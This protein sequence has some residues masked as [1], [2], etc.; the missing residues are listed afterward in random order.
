MQNRY[1]KHKAR[2]VFIFVAIAVASLAVRLLMNYRF[3]ETALLYVGIPFAIALAL[4]LLR[5]PSEDVGWKKKYLNK[6]I[7]AFIIM[8]GTSVVLFEG[9]VCVVMFMPIYL[10]VILLMF[11]IDFATQHANKHS[12]S[13][14]S[15]HIL[16][17]LIVLSSLEGVVAPLSFER[18]EHVV[19]TRVVRASVAEIQHNLLQSMDLQ[20]SRPWFLRLFPMPYAIKAGSLSPGDVHEIHFRYYRWFVTNMHEG[21]MLLQISE[22]SEKRIKTRILED[23]SYIAN[24]L[25]LKGTEVVLQ[26]IDDSRT[27]VTL[28]VDFERTLDP[29]W[30]FAPVERYGI[31]KTAEF[32]IT[33]VIA[34]E[35]S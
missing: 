29:Y 4:I 5:S 11:I 10:V 35:T 31:G 22:A 14:L 26:K 32:L 30:Y 34:R 13:R 3:H 9:F 28:R 17:V 33:E 15:M 20:K 8:L 7:D 23:S 6:L 18:D 25:R 16:P 27:R 21:R 24:Y 2:M 12:H 19:V 1:F